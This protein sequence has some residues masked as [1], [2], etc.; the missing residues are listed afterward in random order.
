MISIDPQVKYKMDPFAAY[1]LNKGIKLH[2]NELGTYDGL[3]YHFKT[4]EA[5]GEEMKFRSS[6]A[7]NYFD[8]ISQNF[9]RND[10][11][12]LMSMAWVK[13]HAAI[14]NM[15]GDEGLRARS[16]YENTA[17]LESIR[18]FFTSPFSFDLSENF[19]YFM[20]TRMEYFEYKSLAE[21]LT[22]SYGSIPLTNHPVDVVNLTILNL[23]TGF[24]SKAELSL[25]ASMGTKGALWKQAEMHFNKYRGFFLLEFLEP[26]KYLSSQDIITLQD[27]RANVIKQSKQFILDNIKLS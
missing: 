11:I 18:A 4:K 9:S 1:Q 24:F 19:R 23:C 16:I 7:A 22:Q 10:Y 3:K 12:Q 15:P 26:D 25:K 17:S 6:R 8:T 5:Q 27:G 2:F 14:G 20:K 13:S 21:M